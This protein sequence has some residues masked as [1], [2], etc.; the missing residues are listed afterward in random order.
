MVYSEP[1]F[2]LP[3]F[4]VVNLCFWRSFHLLPL[5][6]RR[7]VIMFIKH[8]VFLPQ[9]HYFTVGAITKIV[10]FFITSLLSDSCQY[11]YRRKHTQNCINLQ[12]VEMFELVCTVN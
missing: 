12:G 3:A 4:I 8:V 11:V 2:I 10:H 5:L 7:N 1:G 6:R 9:I